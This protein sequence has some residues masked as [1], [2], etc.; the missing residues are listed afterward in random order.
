[1]QVTN[2]D[3]LADLMARFADAALIAGTVVLAWLF[4]RPADDDW[5]GEA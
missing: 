3:V 2:P 5:E 4:V 1:M